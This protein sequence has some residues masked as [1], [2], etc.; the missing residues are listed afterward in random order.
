MHTNT[1]GSESHHLLLSARLAW[2]A[3]ASPSATSVFG[4]P[5]AKGFSEG[6]VSA[7]RAKNLVLQVLLAP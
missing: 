5:R 1:L 7:I 6:S 2:E 4:L 3:G